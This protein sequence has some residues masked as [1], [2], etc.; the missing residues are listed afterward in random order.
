[1]GRAGRAEKPGFAVIQTTSPQSEVIQAAAKQ[2][3]WAFF[4]GESELRR[5]MREPPFVRFTQYLISSPEDIQAIRA[6]G[7]LSADLMSWPARGY[8]DA[9]VLGPA[10]APTQAA[11][12]TATIVT[13]RVP[14]TA[15]AAR[16]WRRGFSTI[17]PA[18]Q[19]R[20][21]KTEMN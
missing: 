14:R 19:N 7:T 16:I 3:Y 5:A 9:G 18:P 20:K 6:A 13:L 17:L 1:M 2:D 11:T 12:D 21:I 15:R 4:E 10:Q 8:P